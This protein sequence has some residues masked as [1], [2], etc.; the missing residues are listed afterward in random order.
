MEEKILVVD[1]EKGIVD[2]LSYA[3]TREG[4]IVE[5]AY[6]GEEALNKLSTFHP[7]LMILDIMMPKL[8][9]FEVCKRM[10]NRNDLGILLLTA[11]NDIVDKVLG[12]EFGAD[13]YI[14][15][16]FDIRELIARVK[17][18]LRRL[19]KN[20]IKQQF[21]KITIRD[22]VVIA[23]QRKV[24]LRGEELEFTPKEFDLLHLLLSNPERVYE[25][26]RLL[27]L[28]WGIEYVGGTRTVDIHVQ[29][30]RSKLGESYQELLQTVYGIGYKAIGDIYENRS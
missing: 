5:T 26:D 25:R 1:D 2:A 10:D 15:K 7:D 14:I 21:E 17:A 16:P 12:F 4:F 24:V 23:E 28:V 29:R 8:N 9:G 22:L 13:D 18:L 11:K 3:F 6:N 20:S 19:H 30:I 27:D